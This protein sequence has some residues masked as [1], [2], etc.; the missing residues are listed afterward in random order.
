MQR[1]C[2]LDINGIQNLFNFIQAPVVLRYVDQQECIQGWLIAMA[3]A[4]H[5]NA[6]SL[7]ELLVGVIQ[8]FGPSLNQLRGQCFDGA[9]NV[10][11]I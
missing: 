1:A 2:L 7:K 4:E 9:R 10:S 3:I 11:G 6:E 5:T 8:N